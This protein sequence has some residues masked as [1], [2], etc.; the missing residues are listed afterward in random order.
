MKKLIILLLVLPFFSC[1][2]K[3][4]VVADFQPTHFKVESIEGLNLSEDMSTMSSLQDEIFCKISF[5]EKENSSFKIIEDFQIPTMRFNSKKRIHSIDKSLSLKE[6]KSQYVVFSLVELD[7][8]N[9]NESLHKII[10]EKIEEGIFLNFKSPLQIDTL[11][12]DDD[13]LG[14]KY[15]DLFKP[16]K[17]GKQVVKISGRQLFDKYDYRIYYHFESLF[18]Q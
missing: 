9:S 13:F 3:N 8:E 12:G 1:S 10:N 6:S 18:S 7:T 5:V 4:N 11:I 2:P 17:E 15:I 14:M 16:K